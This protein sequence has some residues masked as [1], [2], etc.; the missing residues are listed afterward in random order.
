M[1]LLLAACA[2]PEPAPARELD[3]TTL[4]RIERVERGLL[5]AVLIEGEPAWTLAERMRRHGVPGVSVAVIDGFFEL[6]PSLNPGI[7]FG[8]GQGAGPLFA[9]VATLAIPAISI[10]YF[11]LRSPGWIMTSALGLILGG[12]IGNAVDRIAYGAVRDFL[13]F[14]WAPGRPWHTFNVADSCIVVGV[15]LH[16]PG[17]ELRC[18]LLFMVTTRDCV[19]DFEILTTSCTR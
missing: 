14:Y 5:P 3:P 13:T 1:P 19:F 2:G 7:I 15:A 4:E 18:V 9:W 11:R 12:A 10:V 8:I 16:Q 17:D 6:T